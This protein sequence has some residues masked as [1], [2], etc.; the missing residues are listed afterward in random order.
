MK[1][2]HPIEEFAPLFAP[3]EW[4]AE[5]R[6]LNIPFFTNLDQS[7]YA[8]IILLPEPVG[9]LASRSS[10]AKDDLRYIWLHESLYPRLNP[11]RTPEDTEEAWNEKLRSAQELRAF[12]EFTREHSL[13]EVFHD[14]WA[15][16][17]YIK[18]LAQYGDD[19]IAQMAG[20]HIVFWGISQVAIKHLE[21][22]RIGLAPLEKSTRYVDY[23]QRIN[24][25]YMYYTDPTLADLGLETEY[26]RVMDNLFD[27]Y[28][29][30]IPLMIEWL[31]KRFPEEKTSVKRAKAF[32]VLRGLLPASTLSQVAFFGNGQAFEYMINRAARHTLG[33]LRWV[34]KRSKEE[35]DHIMPAFLRRTEKPETQAYQEYLAG[36]GSRVKEGM[37]QYIS[38]EEM[39]SFLAELKPASV[40]LVEWNRNGE[41]DII[42]GILYPETHMEWEEVKAQ[43]ERMTADEKR[44]ILRKA[45]EGRTARWQKVPRAFENDYMRFDVVINLGAYRDLHRHRMMT[46]QRQRFSCHLGYD[47]PPEIVEAGLEQEFRGALDRVGKFFLKI[48]RHDPEL[49]QYATTLAHR[50]RFMMYLNHRQFFWMGELRTIPEGHPDYRHAMQQAFRQ[51]QEA[52][53]LLAKHCLVNMN[54]YD[55]ARRGQDD[56]IK[57]K[58]GE[59]KNDLT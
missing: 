10:R 59:L 33:E 50:M 40:N 4:S 41:D 24:G 21:D 34:A 9:A 6:L 42:A 45:L 36:L 22:Q 30:L 37:S 44:T 13:L 47:V 11:E 48:E 17:F 25:Q 49:A 52:F 57:K 38:K 46:Q 27:T 7:V 23:S 58:E 12:L 5:D 16:N 51:Y 53:P 15:R 35:L 56:K 29:R 32:D 20:G 1:Q 31:N 18:W 28:A 19:S 8:P 14:K 3:I 54:E 39:T 26:R 43:V 55:F 2:E